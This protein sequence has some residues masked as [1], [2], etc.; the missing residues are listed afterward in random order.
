VCPS[1]ALLLRPNQRDLRAGRGIAAHVV[2][3]D[4]K[5][6]VSNHPYLP[7]VRV[8]FAQELDR[9]GV[10][11]TERHGLLERANKIIGRFTSVVVTAGSVWEI[12]TG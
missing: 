2:T 10:T 7:Q 5:A 3:D 11:I 9:D 4:V 8:T 12:T 6:L 1:N